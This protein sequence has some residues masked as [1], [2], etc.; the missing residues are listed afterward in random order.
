MRVHKHVRFHVHVDS[1]D[2]VNEL[3]RDY[4]AYVGRWVQEHG[5]EWRWATYR[6]VD[7]PARFVSVMWHRDEDAEQAHRS[8]DGTERFAEGLYEHVVDSAEIRYELVADSQA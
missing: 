8:A 1:I 4:A 3:I 2:E 7:D 6:E 5:P